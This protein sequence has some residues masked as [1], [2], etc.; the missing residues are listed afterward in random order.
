SAMSG[1]PETLPPELEREIF[2]LAVRVHPSVAPNLLLVAHRVH[3][4]IEPILYETLIILVGAPSEPPPAIL[5]AFQSKPASFFRTHVRNLLLHYDRHAKQFP[6]I[7]SRCSGTVNLAVLGQ[8]RHSLL[9]PLGAMKLQRLAVH[10]QALFGPKHIDLTLP[11]FATLTHLNIMNSDEDRIT[12]EDFASLP[13]LTHLHLFQCR[14]L[15][16]AVLLRCHALK[17]LVSTWA[18]PPE[19]PELRS[20]IQDPR[21]VLVHLWAHRRSSIEDWKAGTEGRPDLWS[22]ADLFVAK[23]HGRIDP[24]KW[25]VV[26]QFSFS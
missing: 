12:A 3:V 1:S 13:A 25:S 21:V 17:V 15:M 18:F 14:A 4:W 22:R 7:L 2:E 24:G 5:Q 10:M 11:C 9:A 16:D 20:L 26:G 8:A 23:R 19:I 6:A